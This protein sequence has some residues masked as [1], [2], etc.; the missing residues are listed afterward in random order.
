MNKAK[1]EKFHFILFLIAF[2]C[3]RC[4]DVRCYAMCKHGTKERKIEKAVIGNLPLESP[5]MDVS[6]GEKWHARNIFVTRT[7]NIR[8]ENM[9]MIKYFYKSIVTQKKWDYQGE[10]VH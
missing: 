10:R 4:D 2:L 3:S 9:R 1:K 6:M 7:T 8:K 5:W